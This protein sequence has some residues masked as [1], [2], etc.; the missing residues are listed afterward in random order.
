M[1]ASGAGW[2]AAAGVPPCRRPPVQPFRQTTDGPPGLAVRLAR[3]LRAKMPKH[4]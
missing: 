4:H 2:L 3:A 1:V